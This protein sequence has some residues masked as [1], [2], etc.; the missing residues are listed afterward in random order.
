MTQSECKVGVRVSGPG[1]HGNADSGTILRV[2]ENLIL[3]EYD[4]NC[5]GHNG[6]TEYS[7]GGKQGHCW[8]E[9]PSSLT[10]LC[11]VEV[12][13][14]FKACRRGFPTTYSKILIDTTQQQDILLLLI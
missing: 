7:T 3:V 9:S 5:G 10:L 13:P 8:Y 4:Q 12:E 1:P 11:E 14:S 6:S 2:S